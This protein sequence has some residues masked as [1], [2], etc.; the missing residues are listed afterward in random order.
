MTKKIKITKA[1]LI[2]LIARTKNPHLKLRLL[3]LLHSLQ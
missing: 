2:R 3:K 1:E